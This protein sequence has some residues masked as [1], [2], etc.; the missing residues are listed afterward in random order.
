MN[1]D[2]IDL[3]YIDFVNMITSSSDKHLPH[4]QGFKKHLKPYWDQSLK[5]LHKVMREKRKAW[6]A[7][8]R[9]RG[10]SFPAYVNYKDAKRTF[11]QYH[12]ICA[13]NYLKT[14][15][16]EIDRAAGLN[17]QYFWRLV[18]RRRNSSPSS[19]GAEIKFD[20]T[21]YKDPQEICTQWGLYFSSLYTASEGRDFDEVHFDNVTSFVDVLRHDSVIERDV[22]L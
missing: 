18:N 5:E 8:N 15:N 20:N 3:L 6:I 7:C 2:I 9:P 22:P 12:R 13:N 16:Q 10:N 21:I 4:V 11:R 1:S 14:L 19:I 17:S